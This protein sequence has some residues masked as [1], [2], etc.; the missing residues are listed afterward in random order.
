MMEDRREEDRLLAR[1]VLQT[2]K[3]DY[4]KYASLIV[5][6]AHQRAAGRSAATAR[7]GDAEK[8][9]TYH[10]PCRLGRHLGVYDAPRNV[11]QAIPGTELVEMDRNREESLCCG[12]SAFTNCD[13]CSK[14]IRVDRLR[15]E[16]LGPT[17][18]TAAPE[19]PDPLPSAR[20][21]ARARRAGCRD[22]S[23]DLG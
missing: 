7:F 19:V 13:A 10:D 2:F 6:P 8:K 22:A 14:Q 23:S 20:W 5:S 9:V 18:T 21:S 12:T 3:E 17:S 15:G 16:P 11:L 1:R 4:P